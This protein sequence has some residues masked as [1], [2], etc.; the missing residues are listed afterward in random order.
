MGQLTRLVVLVLNRQGALGINKAS[1]RSLCVS[2][3]LSRGDIPVAS[4]WGLCSPGASFMRSIL[5]VDL[6][7]ANLEKTEGTYQRY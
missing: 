5:L 3:G 6:Q 1:A 7:V 4:R 2:L